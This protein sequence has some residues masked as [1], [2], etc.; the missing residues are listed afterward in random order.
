[1]VIAGLFGFRFY[2]WI[3]SLLVN[4]F[5]CFD[6]CYLFILCLKFVFECLLVSCLWCN[7]F[8]LFGLVVLFCGLCCGL[9][10]YC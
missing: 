9:V 1:M 8:E 7:C 2:L 6:I 3:L 10:V 5:V 4:S